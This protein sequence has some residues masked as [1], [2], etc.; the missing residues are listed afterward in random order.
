MALSAAAR[1]GQDGDLPRRL[2]ADRARL[3]RAQTGLLDEAAEAHPDAAS[4]S[5]RL[6]LLGGKLGVAGELGG[7][8]E[9]L[10]VVAGVV[11]DG[12][13]EHVAE[14]PVEREL[15]GG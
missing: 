11:D 4:L 9:A 8:A 7:A 12:A 1:A 13:G 14:N 15:V 3:V 2:D 5:A 10:R 6:R